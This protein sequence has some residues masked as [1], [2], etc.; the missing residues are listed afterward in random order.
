MYIYI[1]SHM[2]KEK[3]K[4]WLG[5][6]CRGW[7]HDWMHWD[8]WP[9]SNAK[10]T[11]Y[12]SL[13][14]TRLLKKNSPLG[15]KELLHPSQSK[16]AQGCFNFF[17]FRELGKSCDGPANSHSGRKERWHKAQ[18]W[19][20]QS[21]VRWPWKV[22][23][24]AAFIIKIFKPGLGPFLGICFRSIKSANIDPRDRGTESVQV[25]GCSHPQDQVTSA[26]TALGNKSQ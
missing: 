24:E 6:I 15:D 2:H 13:S 25:Q 22:S 17:H 8:W 11:P 9:I 14:A 19:P 10:C 26:L 7:E 20:L 18:T 5:F 4:G 16:K 3:W 1:F 23:K 12:L 21:M